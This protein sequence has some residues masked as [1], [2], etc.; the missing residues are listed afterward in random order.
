MKSISEL[1]RKIHVRY[2]KRLKHLM[3]RRTRTEILHSA[4]LERDLK[5]QNLKF[6]EDAVPAPLFYVLNKEEDVVFDTLWR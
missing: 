6:P 5:A 1:S 4:I 2:G 3:V